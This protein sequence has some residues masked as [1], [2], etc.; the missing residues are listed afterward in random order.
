MEKMQT[1]Y[2]LWL[3]KTISQVLGSTT[4][5]FL[6]KK[7][8][9]MIKNKALNLFYDK[10]QKEHIMFHTK[11]TSPRHAMRPTWVICKSRGGFQRM[12]PE[13]T[14][15]QI[16]A[17]YMKNVNKHIW[18]IKENSLRGMTFPPLNAEGGKL[19]LNQ[20]MLQRWLKYG[21]QVWTLKHIVNWDSIITSVY[22]RLHMC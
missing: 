5:I 6:R 4:G 12:Q 9:M 10:W 16:S 15:S 21:E 22:E 18:M 7:T 1:Y 17:Q 13:A 19:T 2:P 11:Q 14:F 3:H 8:S 20:G